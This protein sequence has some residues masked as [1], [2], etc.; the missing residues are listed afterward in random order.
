MAEGSRYSR[1]IDICGTA[2]EYN[3]LFI[4]GNGT[5]VAQFDFSAVEENEVSQLEMM[6][7]TPK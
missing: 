1:T 3:C 7:N 5:Q 6:L 4:D 2:I